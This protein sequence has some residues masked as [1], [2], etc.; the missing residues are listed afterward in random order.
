MKNF[1]SVI[2]PTY[3]RSSFLTKA[4]TSVLNQS[5]THLELIVVDDG[6]TD[7]T[8]DVV[9]TFKAKSTVPVR[10]IYQENRGP[11][12]ARNKGMASAQFDFIAFLD[13]DDWFHKNK[14]ALQLS[15]ME[16]NIECNISHTQE[17]WYRRGL[18]LNQKKKHKKDEGDIYRRCLEL[19]AVGMSTIMMHK[20]LI[21]VIGWFDEQM[22]CCEDYDY[23]LRASSRFPFLLIDEPLTYKSGGRT[24]QV[25]SIHRIGIDKF[26]IQAIEKILN[27]PGLTDQQYRQALCELEKKCTLYGNGC[28][29]HGRDEEGEYYLDLPNR[30]QP[31][32]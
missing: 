1:V 3:N 20:R 29:K 15:A 2:I 27:M 16:K 4:I 11:A 5:Y 17:I 19:C 23:W 10:Y 28:K 22:P 6:S 25:S 18:H 32:T 31:V 7:D 21:E 26:R 8:A 9:H 30:F 12:S 13:S 14:I 24:D